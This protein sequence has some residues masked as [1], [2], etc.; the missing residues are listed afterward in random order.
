MIRTCALGAWILAPLACGSPSDPRGPRGDATTPALSPPTAEGGPEPVRVVRLARLIDP[1]D[2][3]SLEPAI[4][5]VRGERVAYVGTDA[6]QIPRSAE[7]VDWS[8][9]SGIPGLV[10]A[11]THLSFQ[12]D[13]GG[14]MS[15]WERRSWLTSE[16]P[17]AITALAR[18]AAERTLRTG[19]TTVIDKGSGPG[20]AIVAAVR[21]AIVAGTAV[22][23]RIFSAGFGIG[24]PVAS[25]AAMRAQVR[26]N[27]DAGVDLVK[28]WADGC[29]DHVLRCTP[30][31]ELEQLTAAVDEAHARGRPIAIHA[32]HPDTA[33]LA[34]QAGPDSLEHAE[35]LDAIDLLDMRA[36][37]IT[38]VPTIDHNR[39]YREHLGFFGYA[40]DDA[41]ALDAFL[42]QNL[43]TAH[44]ALLAGVDLAFGS[45]AV[46]TGFGENT[47]EL[48][49]FV[50]AGMTPL[51]ALRAATLHSAA[52]IGVDHEIGR[53]AVGYFADIVALE[54]DPRTDIR[55]VVHG[56]RGVMKGG[57][58]L[59]P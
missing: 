55:V 16:R 52:S 45:D 44:R 46:F 50:E 6:S 28:V 19:V 15:P 39:Y 2:G 21:D 31:F 27:V 56:V 7:L 13:E 53:V 33:R 17:D 47:R 25:P 41:L 3:S 58:P 9:Y 40:P 49:W 38:Y 8:A 10:D 11:H 48:E 23:P 18:Q 12:T 34:I 30:Q 43:E 35:G 51:E 14:G 22:G 24:E 54:G 42:A 32:Y 5:V 4:V 29:S 59:T 57:V 36:A 20:S 1:A 26:D 37:Q